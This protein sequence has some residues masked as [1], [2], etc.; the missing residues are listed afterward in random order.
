MNIGGG[1]GQQA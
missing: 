1:R